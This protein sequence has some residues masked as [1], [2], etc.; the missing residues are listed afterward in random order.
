M[1]LLLGQSIVAHLAPVFGPVGQPA[2]SG[3][4]LRPVGLGGCAVGVGALGG[5]YADTLE[6]GFP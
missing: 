3:D 4:S 2:D 1:N 6:Y 5:D